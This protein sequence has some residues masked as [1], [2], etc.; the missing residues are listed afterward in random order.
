[1]SAH[2]DLDE[3]FKTTAARDVAAMLAGER[4]H[5]TSLAADAER[6]EQLIALADQLHRALR[7]PTLRAWRTWT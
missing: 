1:M 6:L 3:H 5:D 4:L 2:F 7:S